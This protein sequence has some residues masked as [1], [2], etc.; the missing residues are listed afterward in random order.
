MRHSFNNVNVLFFKT[1]HFNIQ[2]QLLLIYMHAR[3]SKLFANLFKLNKASEIGF[4]IMDQ[5]NS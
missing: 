1:I 4:E 2:N 5:T 3:S